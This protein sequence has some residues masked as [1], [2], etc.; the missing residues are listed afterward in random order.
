MPLC[1]PDL[2]GLTLPIDTVLLAGLSE[3]SH[4]HAEWGACSGLKLTS[5][6]WS[7]A[8]SQLCGPMGGAS[9]EQILC[10]LCQGLQGTVT[11]SKV[12]CSLSEVSS[13]LPENEILHNLWWMWKP[14]FPARVF[15]YLTLSSG[16]DCQSL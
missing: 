14:L 7:Q 10:A 11:Q 1:S 15:W 6:F 16:L 4:E 2:L 3:G 12:P 13:L 9:H 5:T 8:H